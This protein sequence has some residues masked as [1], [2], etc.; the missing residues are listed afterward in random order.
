MYFYFENICPL[1]FLS[2]FSTSNTIHAFFFMYKLKLKLNAR[3][4]NKLI[5]LPMNELIMG[6]C[7]TVQYI[8][9]TGYDNF[10]GT[11]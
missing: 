2:Y 7:H 6:D 8:Q 9:E 10:Y 3:S 5:T 4:A 11:V 1:R